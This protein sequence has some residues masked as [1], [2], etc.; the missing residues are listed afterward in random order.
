MPESKSAFRERCLELLLTGKYIP[1]FGPLSV[2]CNPFSLTEDL[3]GEEGV[4]L[5]EMTPL[6]IDGILIEALEV[7]FE[8]VDDKTSWSMESGV[9]SLSL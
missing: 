6:L 3:L 2:Q 9:V 5:D 8:V 7:V 1:P 4:C